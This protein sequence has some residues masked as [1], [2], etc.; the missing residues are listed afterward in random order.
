[1]EVAHVQLQHNLV[2]LAIY[3]VEEKRKRRREIWVRQWIGR[4]HHFGL[5]DQLMVELRKEDQRSF[6]NFLSMEPDVFD[7]LFEWVGPAITKQ[8]TSCRTPLEPDLKLVVTLRHI[9]SGSSNSATH[10]E[11]RVPYN[12]LSVIVREV[13]QVVPVVNEYLDEVMNCLTTPEEW[14]QISDKFLQ[15]WNFPHACGALD[16]KHIACKCPPHNDS[17]YYNHKGFYSIGLMALVDADYK[18]IWADVGSTGSA[19]NA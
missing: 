13:C 17:E 16:G 2:K 9:A 8:Y 1:M 3:S 4:Q 19:S 11:W 14:C 6:K 18:F 10:H 7:E 15:K 12:T 5:Y